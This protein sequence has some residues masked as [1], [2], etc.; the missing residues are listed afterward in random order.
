M[1]R[2]SRIA[3]AGYPH[4]IVQRGHSRNAVFFSEFDR[5]DYLATL[6]ECRQMFGLLLYGFCLMSNHVHLIVNPG[7]DA[8][9]LG[10]LMKRL[11]G[12][13]SRRMNRLRQTSG[14]V[15]EGR[16]HCSPIDTNRYLLACGRYVDQNPVRAGIVRRVEDFEWSS[17]RARAGLIVCDWLDPDPALADLA[18]S[19]DRRFARYREFAAVPTAAQE[20]ALIRGALQRN[21]LTGD[22]RFVDEILREAGVEVSTHAPGRPAKPGSERSTADG[23]NETGAIRRPFVDK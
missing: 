1:P 14:S 13:H 10:N 19:A 8:R 5:A 6:Q 4:H 16:F 22:A 3:F 17:Y 7:Q 15:W 9:N 12:R 20:L 18:A 23:R 2:R 21:Q 11:A